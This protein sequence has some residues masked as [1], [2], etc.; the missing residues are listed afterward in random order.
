MDRGLET[1]LD[2]RPQPSI[3][4]KIL[5]KSILKVLDHLVIPG[6]LKESLNAIDTKIW[7]HETARSGSHGYAARGYVPHDKL[8]LPLNWSKVR[9]LR[10]QA[11]RAAEARTDAIDQA[12]AEE[13]SES[14]GYGTNE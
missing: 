4:T 6:M 11:V 14:R 5:V 7:L 13:L 3:P 10:D 2:Y 9:E 1:N 8:L 12:K